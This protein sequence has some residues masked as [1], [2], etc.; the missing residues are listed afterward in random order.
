MEG[1][2]M[3][4]KAGKSGFSLIEVMIAVALLMIGLVGIISLQVTG[5]R[6]LGQAKHRTVATQLASDTLEYLKTVPVDPNNPATLFSTSTSVPL[7]DVESQPLLMDQ[8]VGD[9][10]NTW[11]KFFLLSAD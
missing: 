7:I 6:W 4:H 5:I 3:K 11:H 8:A 2:K 9:G 10:Y 1:M